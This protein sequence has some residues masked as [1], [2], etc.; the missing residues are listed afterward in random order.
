MKLQ[1]KNRDNA[2]PFLNLFLYTL[3]AAVFIITPMAK[4]SDRG[5]IPLREMSSLLMGAFFLVL[6]RRA[7][8][9]KLKRS[10]LERFFLLL[11]IFWGITSLIN[12]VNR[13]WTLYYYLTFYLFPYFYYIGLEGSFSKK[14]IDSD[15][16]LKILLAIVLAN[17]IY[18]AVEYFFHE[19][20]KEIVMFLKGELFYTRYP[21]VSGIFNGR[22]EGGGFISVVSVLSFWYYT[23]KARIGNI[24]GVTIVILSTLLPGSSNALITMFLGFHLIFL[25]KIINI[26]HMPRKI[27]ASSLANSSAKYILIW[28]ITIFLLF[29]LPYPMQRYHNLF[30]FLRPVAKTDLINADDRVDAAGPA[31]KEERLLNGVVDVNNNSAG[32]RILIYRETLEI[33]KNKIWFGIGLRNLQLYLKTNGPYTIQAHN[34]FLN[35]L[36]ETGFFG[37]LGLLTWLALFFRQVFKS[38]LFLSKE[39]IMFLVFL[40]SMQF[41]YFI[42]HTSCLNFLFFTLLAILSHRIQSTTNTR[43]NGIA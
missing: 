27:R 13:L 33:Y 14:I 43:H 35:F 28:I 17:G 36:A 1:L 4:F 25:R 16:V 29:I 11:M 22:T 8:I 30:P 31:P 12:T 18:M 2:I 7:I 20:M 40:F 38:G 34:M 5:I 42:G 21:E 9:Q 23:E 6:S 10:Q 41:D 3:L 39:N 32:K 24:A 26:F 15:I 37:L 19:P